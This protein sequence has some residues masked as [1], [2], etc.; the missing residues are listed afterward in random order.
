MSARP[1]RILADIHID[2]PRPRDL[3]MK[4]TP[5]FVAYSEQTWKLLATQRA[6]AA[7]KAS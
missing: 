7:A 1:G 6:G 5:E 4:R 3:E 2:L